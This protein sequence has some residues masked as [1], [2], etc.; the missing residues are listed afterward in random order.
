MPKWHFPVGLS[1]T[2]GLGDESIEITHINH[3]DNTEK[4][5]INLDLSHYIEYGYYWNSNMSRICK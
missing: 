5:K 1:Y 4:I 2:K 3:D